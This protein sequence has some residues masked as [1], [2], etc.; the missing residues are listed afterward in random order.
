M[1]RKSPIPDPKEA[2]QMIDARSLALQP[3]PFDATLDDITDFLSGHGRV[4]SVRMIRHTN[5]TK[6]FKVRLATDVSG[7]SEMPATAEA[8]SGDHYGD[9]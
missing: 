9:L 1:R 4:M 2:A 8:V 3:F 6:L 7:Q 5:E